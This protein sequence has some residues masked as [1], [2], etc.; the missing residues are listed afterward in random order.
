M[1][2]FLEAAINAWWQGIVLTLM[3][4]LVLRDLPRVSAATR[5][6]IWQ[7]TLGVVLLLPLLQ[8]IPAPRWPES[9]AVEK[10]SIQPHEAPLSPQ[11]P[12]SFASDKVAAS[13]PA[14]KVSPLIEF[15]DGDIF[16]ALAI[17]LALL[18]LLRLGFSY[19]AIRRLKRRAAPMD[20]ELPTCLKRATKVMASGDISM[21]MAVGYFRPA[22]LLPSAMLEN[23]TA[24]QQRHVL[25]HETAHLRRCDDWAALAERL[26]GALF[27]IQ[28]AVYF[29]GRRIERE[30]EIA[31]DDWVVEQ[32]GEAKPYASSLARLAEL[33]SSRR[34]PI[35]ATGVGGKKQIFARLETLLDRTRNRIPA[36]S[37]PLVLLAG[38][39]LLVAVSHGA[40]FNHLF[41]LSSFSNHWSENDGN[42]RREFKMRGDVRF[43]SDD[44]DVES[45]SPDALLIV[46]RG[47]GFNNL[48]RVVF[49]GSEN[50]GVTRRYFIDGVERHYDSGAQRFAASMLQSW[51]REQ[52]NNIPERLT[53]LIQEKG[54][55]GA[56]EDIR[57]IRGTGVKRGYLQELFHQSSP[58]KEQLRRMLKVAGEMNSD[59]DKRQFMESAASRYFEQGMESAVADY[60]DGMHSDDDRRQLL[61]LAID[62][63]K[64]ES[65]PRLLRSVGAIPSDE[66]KAQLLLQA[67]QTSKGPLVEEF[68][69]AASGIH[70]DGE[71]ARLLSAMVATHGRDASELARILKMAQS[72][73]SDE[74]K[75]KIAVEAANNFKGGED[76]LHQASRLLGSIH[77]DGERRS[78]LEALLAGDGNNLATF[79]LALTQTLTMNSDEEKSRVLTLAAEKLTGDEVCRRA[80]FGALNS[81]HS[82]GEQRKVLLA[83]LA[84]AE[85]P[86]G[87]RDE[88]AKAAA[89]IRSNEDRDAVLRALAEKQ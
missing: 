68:Y 60:I 16:L 61:T 10:T 24:E 2:T 80:Y 53:R 67:V 82:S 5:V 59:D 43:T 51:V 47:E 25:L 50:G 73:H 11:T 78:A 48:E 14:A 56:L 26:L 63:A 65:L 87:V 21:P 89:G 7:V 13:R 41:G 12:L 75:A 27:A 52:G 20:A 30:R 85:V 46:E 44:K 86:L 74:E 39:I 32:A 71:R 76:T 49:E 40:R 22:I 3:V 36:V 58:N 35:L 77:S 42:R 18:G 4:W 1:N 54:V 17:S 64:V 66:V 31:C 8:R 28:P 45:M 62:A 29:I 34:A 79:K 15:R 69:D 55:D 84:R 33:G 83:L 23:L 88:V 81:I 9:S 6:A 70:S 72:M 57:L 38:V 19:W 37:E